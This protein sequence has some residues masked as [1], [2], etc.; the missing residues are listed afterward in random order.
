M[1][2]SLYDLVGGSWN[3]TR[4]VAG[5]ARELYVLDRDTN[6]YRVDPSTG[7]YGDWLGEAGDG[8]HLVVLDGKPF[9]FEGPATAL[10]GHLYTVEDRALYAIDPATGDSTRLDNSWDTR[11]LIGCGDSLYAWEA[12]NALY[13]VDP[14]SGSA[15]RLANNWPHTSG[16]A[17]AI[18]RLY[19]VDG[20]ILYQ[21]DPSSGSCTA[22]S[23]RLHT[24]LLAG[25]GSSIYS[26]ER[27][28][29]LL[30]IGVG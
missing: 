6:V 15:T 11:H 23:D 25:A 29:A 9:A 19:A 5:T 24:R 22:I 2:D 12:D 13:R 20:G 4:A 7:T 1:S 27:D 26:F 28:G 30:R 3:S 10:G 14:R 8:D 21:I 16:V 18:G 17:T